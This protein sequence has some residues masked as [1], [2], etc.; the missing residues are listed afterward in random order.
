MKKSI[1]AVTLSLATIPAG[2]VEYPYIGLD[3]LQMDL[4]SQGFTEEVSPEAARLRFGAVLHKYVAME[5]HVLVGTADDVVVKPGV[6]YGVEV[7]GIYS[8]NLAARLPLGDVGSAYAHAGYGAVRM[9]GESSSVFFPDVSVDDD[10]I[11]FGATL[12]FKVWREWGVEIDYTSYLDNDV[13]ELTAVGV[14][15]RRKL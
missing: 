9:S 13:N 8:L 3:Y 14:G 1:A 4:A 7:D 5:A 2:A 10:G 15:I 6:R 11:T 12:E